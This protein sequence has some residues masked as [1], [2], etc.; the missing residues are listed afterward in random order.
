MIKKQIETLGG[1]ISVSS[2]IDVRSTFT[3]QFK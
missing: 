3:I 2:K 1:T